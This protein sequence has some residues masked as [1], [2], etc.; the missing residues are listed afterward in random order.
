MVCGFWAECLPTGADL[1]GV[2]QRGEG[3]EGTEGPA[4]DS[5]ALGSSGVPWTSRLRRVCAG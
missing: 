2:A 1:Q 5:Q 3:G 4:A